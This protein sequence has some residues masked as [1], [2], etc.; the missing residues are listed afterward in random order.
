MSRRTNYALVGFF[1]LLLGT[2]LVAVLLWLSAG[3]PGRAFDRYLVY[4]EESV[5]GLSRDSTV[6]Y[7]G[8]D[9]G[10]VHEISLGPG[11]QRRVRL[12]LQI[13]RGTPIRQDTVATLETQGLTGLAYLNLTGGREGSPMLEETPG[14]E[15]PVIHSEPSIWGRLDRSLADLVDNL[16]E[17]SERLKLLL[18]DENQRLI[19]DT[20]ARASDLSALL[21]GRAGT[22]A[23][24]IDDAAG[25]MKRL[26]ETGDALPALVDQIATTASALEGMAGE[27]GAAGVAVRRTAEAGGQE[28]RRLASEAL[29][30]ILALVRELHLAAGNFRRFSEELERDPGVILHGAAAGPPGPGE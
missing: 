12:L 19:T 3:G 28:V 9:V 26:R 6:K 7:Y 22:L 13:D 10:R 27:L 29:P 8:V 30:E 23:A 15:F 18:S 24:A 1:V 17:A 16:I 11:E 20:L 21:S 2:A 14:E 25:T 5:S 4:M